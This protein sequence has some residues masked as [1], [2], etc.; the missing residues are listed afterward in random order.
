MIKIPIKMAFNIER[1]PVPAG[2]AIILFG[3][4][5]LFTQYYVNSILL[6]CGGIFVLLVG[7]KKK[8]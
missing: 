5:L 7:K 1:N 3:I 4:I 8:K 2:I 6:I